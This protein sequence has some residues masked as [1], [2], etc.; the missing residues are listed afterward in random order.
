MLWKRIVLWLFVINLGVA[1][2]A[3]VYE[4]R[5]VVPRWADIPPDQWPN[6]GLLFWA[7]VTTV[8]L[9]LL[10]ILNAIAA[11]RSRN[12][13][14]RWHLSATAVVIVERLATFSYFIPMMIGLMGSQGLSEAE[15]RASLAQWELLNYVRHL[16][17]LTGWILALKALTKSE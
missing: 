3:G 7:Y 6:T 4:S 2:G 13:R 15:M 10:T 12:P 5:V 14:R 8:P 11:Y 16:L 17:T 1:F 9:T